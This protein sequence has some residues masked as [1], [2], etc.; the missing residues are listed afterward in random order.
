[1]TE[2]Q[3]H[4]F[5]KQIDACIQIAEEELQNRNS[6]YADEMSV[7]HTKLQGNYTGINGS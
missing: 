2:Q 4:D 1:M 7:V 3:L 6:G 5:R